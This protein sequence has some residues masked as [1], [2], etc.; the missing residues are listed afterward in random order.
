MYLYLKKLYRTTTFSLWTKSHQVRLPLIPYMSS[1]PSPHSLFD[2]HESEPE[3][4]FFCPF[5]FPAAAGS[6]R[7]LRPRGPG[8]LELGFWVEEV[9][10]DIWWGIG[11]GV[12][13]FRG[14]AR[15]LKRMHNTEKCLESEKGV[16]GIRYF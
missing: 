8:A 6:V 16:S 5:C 14:A 10:G 12:K 15:E 13:R 2:C 11:K 3:T 9:K 1:M 7:R 4:L